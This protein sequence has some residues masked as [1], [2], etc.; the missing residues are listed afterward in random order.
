MVDTRPLVLL[1]GCTGFI[2]SDILR[3][4]IAGEGKDKYRIRCMVR[5]VNNRSKIQALHNGIGADLVNQIEFVSGDMLDQA[6]IDAGCKGCD[7]I[8]HTA[9]PVNHKPKNK[10]DVIEPA[11]KGTRYIMEAAQKY[12]VKRVVV[13][14]SVGSFLYT[15][16]FPRPMIDETC[17]SDLDSPWI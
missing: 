6:A 13:T 8:I 10:N 9:S 7:F 17:F 11:V 14:S 1:T 12:Q 2:G 4:L 5:D 3:E 16:D 15:K